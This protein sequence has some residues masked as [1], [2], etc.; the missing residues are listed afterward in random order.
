MDTVVRALR[1]NGAVP[2]GPALERACRAVVGIEMGGLAQ[3][4]SPR[5][6]LDDVRADGRALAPGG[7]HCPLDAHADDRALRLGPGPT[8]GTNAAWP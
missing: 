4:V 3:Q 2:D 1:Q 7:R 5:F 8:D 6:T